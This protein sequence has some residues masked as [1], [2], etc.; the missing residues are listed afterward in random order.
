[1]LVLV[2]VILEVGGYL[3]R[4]GRHYAPKAAGEKDFEGALAVAVRVLPAKS[5]LDS[6]AV[7]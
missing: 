5:V 6:F 7:R 3:L 1:M 2:M 4:P